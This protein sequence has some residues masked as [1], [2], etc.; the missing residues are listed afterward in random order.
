M[1]G[2]CNNAAFEREDNTPNKI[3]AR[4]KKKMG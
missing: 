3:H 1:Q 4:L 2:G